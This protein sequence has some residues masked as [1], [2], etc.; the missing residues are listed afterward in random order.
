MGQRG[1]SAFLQSHERAECCALWAKLIG[2]VAT[3]TQRAEADATR[4]AA[5]PQIARGSV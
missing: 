5:V 4:R 2:D 1:R 3:R